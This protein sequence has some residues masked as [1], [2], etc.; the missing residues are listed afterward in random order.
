MNTIV[1]NLK[2]H[3]SA[4]DFKSEVVSINR[5]MDLE[6]EMDSLQKEMIDKTLFKERLSFFN[7]HPEEIFPNAKSIIITAAR[8]PKVKVLFHV[9]GKQTPAFIPPTYSYDTD[10]KL[11]SVI[12]NFLDDYGFEIRNC[13][14]PYKSMAVHSGLADYRKNNITYI[15]GWG[16]FFRLKAYISDMPCDDDNWQDF[17]MMDQCQKCKACIKNCPTHTIGEDRFLLHV[18]KCLT[19]FNEGTN[20]FPE[21]IDPGI[22]HCFIGCMECQ[23]VCPLNKDVKEWV[24]EGPKFTEIET[25][26]ILNNVSKTELPEETIKKIKKL[27]LLDDYEVLGRNLRALISQ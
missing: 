25:R 15:P 8:Q 17:Q 11:F 13:A 10:R 19:H 20:P 14:V 7:F 21:W 6:L 27:S 1:N 4:Y 22:H 18:E 26:M 5:L 12:T 9:D 23:K 3:L 2:S 16:S 24:E